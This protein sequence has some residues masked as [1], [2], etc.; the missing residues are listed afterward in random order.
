MAT[1]T[2]VDVGV[3]FTWPNASADSAANPDQICL[4]LLV[5]FRKFSDRARRWCRGTARD[6][7][8]PA[9]WRQACAS[10]T[11]GQKTIFRC[12]STPQGQ[13]DVL[14]G[15]IRK[16][17]SDPTG[18][19]ISMFVAALPKGRGAQCGTIAELLLERLWREP[20]SQGS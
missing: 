15:S 6:L 17:L 18:H 19:S 5:I 12:R 1:P 20:T 4:Q 3:K 9:P 16:D 11:I 2:P 13:D 7:P 10:W 8:R 14:A